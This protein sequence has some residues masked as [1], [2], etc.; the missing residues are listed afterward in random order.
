MIGFH[1]GLRQIVAALLLLGVFGAGLAVTTRSGLE[2]ADMTFSNQSEVTTLDPATV[3]GVP[4]GRIL[5]AIFEGLCIKHPKTLEPVPGM[6]ERWELSEDGT[7]YTFHIRRGARWSNGDSVSAHDFVYSFERFLNPETGAEYAYQLWYVKGAK[8]YT[9]GAPIDE[10]DTDERLRRFSERV[11]IR[12]LGEYT[13]RIELESPTPYFL[14][15]CAFYPLFPVNRRNIEDARLQYPDTWQLEW[16]RPENIV[17]NGPYK[18]L[19]RRVNDRIRLVKNED[20][21]DA[22]NVAFGIIDA[23]AIDNLSTELKLYLT[24]AVD[25]IT[26]LPASVIPKMMPRE[27]F[28][29]TPYLGSYFYRVNTTR[30]PFDDVRIRR[31]LALTIDRRAIC[32]SVTRAG[33]Q[34]AWAYVPPGIEGYRNAEM[35]HASAADYQAG[36][37]QDIVEAKR[38]L[39]EAGFGPGGKQLPT[40]EIHYNTQETHKDI[41]EVIADSWK[42]HLGLKVKLLNQEWKVYLDTQSNLDFDVSRSAWIGDYPDPNTFLD[43]FV[44]GG[45]NNKTGWGNED[46]DRLVREAALELDKGRRL[47]LLKQSEA[48]LMQELP[49]LPIYFYV[50][51]NVVNPRLGGFHENVQDDHF[52]KFWYWMSDEELAEKRA[53][54]PPDWIRTPAE[55]PSEGQY[56]PTGSGR[57]GR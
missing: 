26:D 37:E 29:P 36:L 24:G 33:Q 9:T 2:P 40:I 34:P 32:E 18:V 17:T 43:M 10:R 19:Y 28:N 21:W 50:T 55:G 52:Q 7:A 49:V 35:A 8:A 57:N 41:A 42:R 51:K 4:E 3:T 27:D 25:W 46:Y 13:L 11:A 12:A 6:A 16:L 39:A 22:D 1:V 20:Y 44:T 53:E 45:E 14:D 48:I 23:L 30:P 54:Q 38:L 56:P 31:A 47:E 15:L 5:R